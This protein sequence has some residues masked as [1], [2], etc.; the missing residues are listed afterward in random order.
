VTFAYIKHLWLVGQRQE[1]FDLLSHFVL[2]KKLLLA[3]AHEELGMNKLLAR[4][5]LKLGDW[6]TQLDERGQPGSSIAPILQYF[7]RA[8]EYDGGWYK[9]WHAWAFMNFQAVLEYK[10]A[11]TQATAGGAEPVFGDIRHGSSQSHD[12]T[13]PPDSSPITYACSAVQGFFRSIAL[14]EE[15]SL[16][17]TLRLL[18]LWFDYGHLPEVHE[19]LLEGIRTIDIDTWL[20]VVY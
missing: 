19:A 18:T 8:T 12:Q 11:T 17:D 1:A 9:A 6:R 4:C 14:S 3:L 2:S 5:Y 7:K 16:Q 13:T 20:Q 15:S 10:Q